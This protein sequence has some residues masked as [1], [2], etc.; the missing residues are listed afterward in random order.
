MR[1][2]LGQV[3]M[4]RGIASEIKEDS[5]YKSEIIKCLNRHHR[6]DWGDVSEEDALMNNT[7]VEIGEQILSA[8]QTS[9]DR[10][11]IITEHDRS[12]TTV[13]FPSEY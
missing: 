5:N 7:A 8:Y 2:N 4:T 1:F 13:L 6:C 10:I 9:K 11:W 12:V 3:V